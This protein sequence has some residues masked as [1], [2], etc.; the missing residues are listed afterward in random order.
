MQQDC[1]PIF[2]QLLFEEERFISEH[3]H[4]SHKK[5]SLWEAN[6]VLVSCIARKDGCITKICH[7]EEVRKQVYPRS[8]QNRSIVVLKV[9][10]LFFR[11]YEVVIKGGRMLQPWNAQDESLNPAWM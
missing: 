2:L 8:W 7:A 10:A 6:D 9:R 4:T 11:A 5:R 1:L 3:I